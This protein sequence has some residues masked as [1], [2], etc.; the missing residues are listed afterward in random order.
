MPKFKKVNKFQNNQLLNLLLKYLPCFLKGFLVFVFGILVL[1]LAYYKMSS[2]KETINYLIYIFICLGAFLVGKS[3]FNKFKGRGILTGALGS[4]PYFL[5]ILILVLVFSKF[6]LNA[7]I[8][9]IPIISI[10]FGS[11]GGII[12]ANSKKRYWKEVK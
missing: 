3:T 2:H 11:V 8:L 1:T 12:G 7:F 5:V 4:V 6:N 10:I 9:I